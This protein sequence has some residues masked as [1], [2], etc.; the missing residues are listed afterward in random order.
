MVK[1]VEGRFMDINYKFKGKHRFL[2]KCF[3]RLILLSI[4]FTTV[5]F[6]KPP[7]T[8][9]AFNITPINM[10][11]MYTTSGTPVYAVPDLFSPVVIYLDRFVNVRVYG[12]TDNGFFQVDLN[13]T[14]YIPGPYM[15]T[16]IA[17][18]KTE[19]QK[20]LDNLG[21]FADTY[22]KLLEQ[23]ESY[24]ENFALIDVTGDGV[25]ELFDDAGR[26]IY[27]YY[28]EPNNERALMMYYSENPV[29]FYYSKK[30]NVLLGKYTWNK[31]DIWEV[32][33]KDVSLLPWG[34]F[35]CISTAASPYK[36]NATAI[37]REYKNNAETR[38]DL[39]NILKKI[40]E[41]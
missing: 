11:E 21:D 2:K 36:D 6:C 18:I 16:Q 27:T 26:E 38:A 15:V 13:G 30:D 39:Y 31:K 37:T 28:N 7:A 14:F 19:K 3:S 10:V 8:A 35:K 17:E 25:P 40:L 1:S 34:Q 33:T 41:L 29:T 9:Y 23:M 5:I 20:A 4:I 22:R 24:S 12:I 32:Y